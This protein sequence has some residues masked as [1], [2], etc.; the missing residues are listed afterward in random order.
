MKADRSHYLV[1]PDR[2]RKHAGF[3]AFREWLLDEAACFA[4]ASRTAITSR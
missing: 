2:S 3:A 4:A 1:Y